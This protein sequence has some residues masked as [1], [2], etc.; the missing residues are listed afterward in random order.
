MAV[1]W[2]KFVQ[3]VQSNQRFILTS[4]I[5]PDCDALGS[6]LGLAEVLRSLGKDVTIVNGEKTPPNLGFIDPANQLY[7]IHVDKTPQDIDNHD[8]L[9]ILDTSA[10]AQLGAMGDAIKESSIKKIINT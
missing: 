9:V 1:D 6:E 5:R 3:L 10:W 7:T 8:L 2:P 4:H